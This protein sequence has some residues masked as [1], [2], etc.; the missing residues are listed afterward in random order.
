MDFSLL[1]NRKVTDILIGDT[2]V[3]GDYKLPYMK[4]SNLCQVCSQF[5]LSKTYTWGGSN[6]SRWEYLQ[7]LMEFMNE[8]GRFPELLS[9]LFSHARFTE[10]NSI[11]DID[12]IHETHRQIVDAAINN[13]NSH[14]LAERKE[15][16]VSNNSFVLFDID[17]KTVI[18][19]PNVKVVTYQSIY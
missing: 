14:L 15:L 1:I 10:L 16:R 17:T 19:T 4:G 8:Q 6:S 11:G 7:S 5:G 12:K 13:I 9:Y 2:V 18:E 3:L